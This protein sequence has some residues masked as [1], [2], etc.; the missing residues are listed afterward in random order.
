[1]RDEA[2]QAHIRRHRLGSS[3]QCEFF[4]G[5]VYLHAQFRFMYNDINH[6]TCTRALSN[7]SRQLSLE[8]LRALDLSWTCHDPAL[9][10]TA[11]S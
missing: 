10:G 9:H 6:N 2:G 3:T 11:V 8:R 1:M 5:R 4:P 7:Q